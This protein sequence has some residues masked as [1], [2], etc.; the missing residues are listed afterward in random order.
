ML[1]ANPSPWVRVSEG[2]VDAAKKAAQDWVEDYVTKFISPE[3][4]A[5]LKA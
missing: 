3:L 5:K 1:L 2:G 4:L